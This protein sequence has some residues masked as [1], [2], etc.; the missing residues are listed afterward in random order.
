MAPSNSNILMRQRTFSWTGAWFL[1]LAIFSA[2]VDAGP[3]LDAPVYVAKVDGLTLSIGKG[4]RQAKT[5]LIT[6]TD[7][8]GEISVTSER[9]VIRR[10]RIVIGLSNQELIREFYYENDALI[11]AVYW[12]RQYAWSPATNG[13]ERTNISGSTEDRQYFHTGKLIYWS[14]GRL[15]ML[16]ADPASFADKEKTLAAESDFFLQV[17]K[18]KGDTVDVESFLKG[19]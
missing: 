1:L 14:T 2:V 18:T 3:S 15:S 13:F 9:G 8:G 10:R 4:H 5:M 6:G 12:R 7:D 16:S 19:K 11:L 17:A